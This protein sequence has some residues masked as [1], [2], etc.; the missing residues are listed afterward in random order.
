M[1]YY[2]NYYTKQLFFVKSVLACPFGERSMNV[3]WTF[4]Q[5]ILRPGNVPCINISDLTDFSIIN[6]HKSQLK[7]SIE[8]ALGNEI[9]KTVS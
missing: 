2:V 3:Q 4:L 9:E 8:Y 6:I 1:N 5:S 7:V